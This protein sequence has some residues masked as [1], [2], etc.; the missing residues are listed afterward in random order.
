VS[1]LNELV[2]R[3][4]QA[5]AAGT[6]AYILFGPILWGLQL[7]IIYAGHTLIC[8]SGLPGSFARIMV[9]AVT[10]IAALVLLAF[11]SGQ[12]PAGRFFG[13]V[14]DTP[15]RHTYDGVARTLG[16]LAMVAII[17]AGGT[18]LVVASCVQAR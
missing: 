2:R 12:R 6:L 9:L 17:W 14:E 4:H 15:G 3:K 5:P 11:L 8:T 7:I 1:Q 13:L 16:I 10:A 18:A